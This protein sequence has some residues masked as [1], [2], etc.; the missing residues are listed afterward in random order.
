MIASARPGYPGSTPFPG[1]RVVD[2][3]SDSAAL[4]DVAGAERYVTLGWSGGGPAALACAR[5]HPGRC[6]AAAT[7]SGPMPYDSDEPAY[8]EG[9]TEEDLDWLAMMRRGAESLRPALVAEAGPLRTISAEEVATSFEGEI[10][11]ADLVALSGEISEVLARSWNLGCVTI[12]GWLDNL[13]ASV[14]PWGFDVSDIECRS[15]LAR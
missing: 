5:G 7:I 1:R 3:A 15:G 14:N 6:L 8:I 10:G 11:P 9:M 2:Y 12:D 4:L 13:I